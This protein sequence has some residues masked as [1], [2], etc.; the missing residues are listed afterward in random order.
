MTTEAMRAAG[1]QHLQRATADCEN[2][3]MHLS[4]VAHHEPDPIRLLEIDANL[5]ALRLRFNLA[6]R[7]LGT[8]VRS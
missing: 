4:G 1:R 6:C 3:L 5:T 2:I 7:L 8:E